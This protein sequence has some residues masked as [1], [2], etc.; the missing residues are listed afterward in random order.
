MTNLNVP[1]LGTFADIAA[2]IDG[3]GDAARSASREI[4]RASTTAKNAA[5]TAMALAM[6]RNESTLLAANA[7]DIVAAQACGHDHAFID[8]LTLSPNA[9][10]AM[11]AGIC[12]IVALP[13]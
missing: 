12:E 6:R 7:D 4:A 9:I 2:Y 10:A 8:R 1:G 11:A 3:V 13:D 5:L